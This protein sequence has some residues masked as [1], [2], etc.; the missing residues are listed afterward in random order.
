VATRAIDRILVTLVLAL[1]ANLLGTAASAC[2][3]GVAETRVGASASVVDVLVE[4]PQHIGAGQR[5]GEAVTGP[6][7]V[8]AT[9]VTA[10]GVLRIV[11]GGFS[12]SERYAAETLAGQGRNV[13]LRDADSAAG[14]TSDLLVNNIA[15]DGCTPITGNLDRI[16]S[17][18]ASKGSQVRAG[19]VVLDL[20]KSSLTPEQVG[21]IL[22]RVQLITS[23]ISDIIVLGGP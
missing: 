1:A 3:T 9:G 16:V 23:Q 2:A 4:P 7:I 11:G 21:N 14:R 15:Y 10:N 12:T 22:P 18:I 8:V 20:S 13:V 6:D 19:G 5:L 17:S